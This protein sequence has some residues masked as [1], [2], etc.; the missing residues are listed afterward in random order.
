MALHVEDVLN[1]AASLN[2]VRNRREE[3]GDGV[4]MKSIVSRVRSPAASIV[5]AVR[6]SA[7]RL[8]ANTTVR[9]GGVASRTSISSVATAPNTRLVSRQR[10]PTE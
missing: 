1:G 4:P 10:V 3:C 9:V 8:D 7:P 5:Y 6:Y 2:F